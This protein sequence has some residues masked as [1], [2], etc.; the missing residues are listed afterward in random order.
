MNITLKKISQYA[1][2]THKKVFHGENIKVRDYCNSI[3][4][5]KAYSEQLKLLSLQVEKIYE[6]CHDE[7]SEKLHLGGSFTPDII[8]HKE[9]NKKEIKSVP[10]APGIFLSEDEVHIVD[11]IS[12]VSNVKLY[13]VKNI[14]QFALKV[15]GTL[16]RGNIGNISQLDQSKPNNRLNK[17][18]NTITCNKYKNCD[19]DSCIFYHDPVNCK[20]KPNTIRNFTNSQFM[21]SSSIRCAKNRNMNHVGHRNA[22]KMDIEKINKM[23]FHTA[24]AELDIH[25]SQT[26]HYLLTHLSIMR[27]MSLERLINLELGL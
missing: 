18:P 3:L 21:Y 23:D 1:N 25:Q 20:S 6:A 26:M 15:N 9:E 24:Q 27:Y 8:K 5:L 17:L 10:V 19:D 12:H 22:L 7:I 13:Y 11:D 16:I 4:L 14:D 2:D